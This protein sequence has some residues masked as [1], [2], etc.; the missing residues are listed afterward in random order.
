MALAAFKKYAAVNQLIKLKLMR[1][2]KMLHVKN[3]QN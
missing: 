1:K 2:L 3:M